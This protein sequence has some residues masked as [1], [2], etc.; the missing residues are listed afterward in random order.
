MPH[1]SAYEDENR[2]WRRKAKWCFVLFAV[3][4]IAVGIW[5]YVRAFQCSGPDYKGGEARKVIMFLLAGLLGPLW[6]LIYPIAAQQ[7]YCQR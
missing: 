4:W 1:H 6:F 3:I 2:E 5:A 7:G